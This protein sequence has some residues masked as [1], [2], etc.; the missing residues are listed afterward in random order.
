MLVY[1]QEVLDSVKDAVI[2]GEV[3]YLGLYTGALTMG[4]A[5]NIAGNGFTTGW[6]NGTVPAV[7]VTEVEL[8]WNER[9]GPP[10]DHD[11]MLEPDTRFGADAFLR[12]DRTGVTFDWGNAS[13]DLTPGGVAAG[14]ESQVQALG[15][16]LSQVNSLLGGGGGQ[17]PQGDQSLVDA[18]GPRRQGDPRRKSSRRS[19]TG[20]T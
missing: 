8:S 5:F 11:A 2:E 15:E 17:S 7:P 9:R 1:A 12:P 19:T 13:I 4:V 10:H 14:I 18:G 3:E 16:N 20:P 6:E